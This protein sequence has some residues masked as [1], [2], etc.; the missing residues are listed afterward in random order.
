MDWEKIKKDCPKAF[1]KFYSEWVGCDENEKED[2]LKCM[3]SYYLRALY[4]FFDGNGIYV[5]IFLQAI[6]YLGNV[7]FEYEGWGYKIWLKEG[8]LN[9][10][11]EIICYDTRKKAEESALERAFEILED[12]L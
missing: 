3:K 10:P 12:K 6:G 5:I 11:T 7:P 8:Q 9:E 2:F 4:D 1:E